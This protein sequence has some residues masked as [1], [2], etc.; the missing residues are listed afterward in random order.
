MKAIITEYANQ[1]FR[2][3]LEARWAAFFDLA[4]W[5]WTYEPFDLE[6]W[7]PDFALHMPQA[8]VLVE[9]KPTQLVRHDVGAWV[10]PSFCSEFDKATKHAEENWVLALGCR[11]QTHSDFFSIGNLYGPPMVAHKGTSWIEVNGALSVKDEMYL[12]REAGNL[13][14]WLGKKQQSIPCGFNPEAVQ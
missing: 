1:R 14:Q 7:A 2:S 6:G 11:P 10:L 13:V 4:G 12:W 5:E 9:V 3:R 8:N